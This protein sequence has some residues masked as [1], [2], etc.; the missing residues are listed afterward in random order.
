MYTL[1][2][3]TA[4]PKNTVA[5]LG[6]GVELECITNAIIP[7]RWEFSISGSQNKTFI[8]HSGV[9]THRLRDK[10][11]MDNSRT[12]RYNLVMNSVDLSLGG[13]YTCSDTPSSQS[14]QQSTRLSGSADLILIGILCTVHLS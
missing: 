14:D 4:V 3:L 8:Y 5:K 2:H 13:T 6:D 9:I 11:V 1:G 12:G 10:Y 7:V